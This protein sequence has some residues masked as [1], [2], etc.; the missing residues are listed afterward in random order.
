[1]GGRMLSESVAGSSR[2]TQNA[3]ENER[4]AFLRGTPADVKDM[5]RDALALD[6]AY[7][8]R[9]WIVAPHETTTRPQMRT[10]LE[11]LAKE[12][13]FDENRAVVVEHCKKRT[14]TNAA[15]V[16]WHVL[17]G[18]VD[19]ATGRILRSSFDRVIHELI[20][21]ISE[22]TFGH[23]FVRGKHTKAVINRLRKR[24]LA[25]IADSLEK[26]VGEEMAIPS[27]AFTHAQHQEKKRL[28]IDLPHRRQEIRSILA[29]ATT[30]DELL[31]L[32]S[33]ARME[34]R[35]GDKLGIWILVDPANGVLI[36]ALHRLAGVRKSE[37][38]ALMKS[39]L[40]IDDPRQQK[41]MAAPKTTIIPAQQTTE[42]GHPH[43]NTKTETGANGLLDEFRRMESKASEILKTPVP[44]FSPSPAMRS[45]TREIREKETELAAIRN[46]RWGLAAELWNAPPPRW[47][48]YPLGLAKRRQSK[49][50]DLQRRIDAADIK[51]R[52]VQL[53]LS[54]RETRLVRETK[55]ANQ[56]FVEDLR[57]ANREHNMANETLKNGMVA[58]SI[59]QANPEL[60]SKGKNHVMALARERMA[61][62]GFGS[63]DNLEKTTMRS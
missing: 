50:T 3:D 52:E 11:L 39:E 2:N 58:R 33:N 37:I 9:H 5:H 44:T 55:E 21:R 49:I 7:S 6:A 56:M 40:K 8:V 20:S 4:I 1:M 32:V 48:C 59:I 53:E 42:P 25:C 38:T 13:G 46:I 18:E 62:N 23:A 63:S 19:P 47:W 60:V 54:V 57:R 12:F 51:V 29:R 34:L 14:V 41:K 31:H 15:D 43:L 30:K 24:N 35:E 16:H 17:V 36:G 26:I 10:V 22:H 28:G 61:D 27:E 45:T